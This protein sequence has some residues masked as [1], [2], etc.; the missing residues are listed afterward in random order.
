MR[1][2]L[3]WALNHLLTSQSQ[4]LWEK[5]QG[6]LSHRT[7]FRGCFHCTGLEG[8]W[9]E[10]TGFVPDT[11]AC[12]LPPSP[13]G[14]K[15]LSGN[16][17]GYPACGPGYGRSSGLLET[18]KSEYFIHSFILLSIHVLLCSYKQQ[19]A[20]PVPDALPWGSNSQ[21]PCFVA[22]TRRPCS[23]LYC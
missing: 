5:F 11:Q 10:G 8:S 14:S 9:A 15:R 12:P 19:P 6:F 7:G 3:L 2:Q 22:G 17:P 18:A 20:Q 23:G 1:R 13:H 16:C 21:S 4:S